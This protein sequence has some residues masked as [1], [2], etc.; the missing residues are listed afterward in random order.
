MS[1]TQLTIS[2]TAGDQATAGSFAVEVTNPSPGGGASNSV[3]FT[4][5]NPAPTIASLSPSSVIIGAAA[6]TLTIYGTNFLSGSTVTYN[7]VAHTTTF[8]SSTQLTIP[9]T[10]SN[11][12]TAGC[13]AVMVT[14]SS[15]GG[16]A[17][18]SVNFTVNNPV[19]VITSLSPSSARVGA[20]AQTLTINGTSFLP[21]S[22]VAYGGVAHGITTFVSSTQ[23]SIL[24]SASD[25]A[26]VS[27]YSVVVTNPSPG[28]GPSNSINFIVTPGFVLTG[29]LN[30]GRTEHTATLLNNGMVLVAGGNT[31][32]GEPLASAELYDPATGTFT[33]T[34]S[35]NTARRDQTATLLNNGMVLIAGGEDGGGNG[36]AS[37]ELYNPANG[38]FTVTGSLNTARQ[39]DTATLLN[40]GMVLVAGGYNSS[41]LLL[42]SAE[43]YDPTAGVFTVTGSLNAGRTYQTATLLNN[44]TVLVVGGFTGSVVLASAE[45][46]EPGP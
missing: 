7:A 1:S 37:A 32:N 16:G 19:P 30:T 5:N 39:F 4:V 42:A 36:I 14:N 27:L 46:Y 35:L 25:Q 6:Q 41:G 43:L 22:T 15:P 13:F 29:S 12:A 28:G 45:L 44:G 18:D 17:S 3:N 23:L 8:V 34:G 9:L 38:T 31:S 20:A 33:L 24:L 2:L 40:N 26:T 10:A 21:S 11:Q